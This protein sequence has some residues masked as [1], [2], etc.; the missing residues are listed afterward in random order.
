MEVVVGLMM[1]RIASFSSTSFVLEGTGVS[2]VML[3]VFGLELDVGLVVLW[4]VLLLILLFLAYF[5]FWDDAYSNIVILSLRTRAEYMQ[6]KIH[7]LHQVNA[8]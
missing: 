6:I 4:E 7:A 5:C 1:G 8:D 3:L 2:K